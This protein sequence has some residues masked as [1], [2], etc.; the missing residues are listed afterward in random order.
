[1]IDEG[2]SSE[3]IE[4]FGDDTAYCPACGAEIWDQAPICPE[5]GEAIG[6]QTLSRP[7]LEDWLH[8]RWIILVAIIALIAFVL[9]MM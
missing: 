4:R 7:P 8:K 9:L 6:G 5:C 1:M 3:D 2:P